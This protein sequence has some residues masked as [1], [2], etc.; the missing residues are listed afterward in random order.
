VLLASI[1]GVKICGGAEMGTML[2]FTPLFLTLSPIVA[3]AILTAAI[4][5]L[6]LFIRVVIFLGDMMG[7]A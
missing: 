4:G 5:L 7:P 3:H 2:L 1:L 6:R